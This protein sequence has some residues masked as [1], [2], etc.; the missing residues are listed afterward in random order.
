M[1]LIYRSPSW[2]SSSSSS[3]SSFG[4]V[5]WGLVPFR[6]ETGAFF[7]PPQWRLEE[8]QSHLIVV[9]VCKHQ[10]IKSCDEGRQRPKDVHNVSEL[11]DGVFRRF[12]GNFSR[13]G[14]IVEV[15]FHALAWHFW[16]LCQHLLWCRQFNPPLPLLSHS[17]LRLPCHLLRLALH[18]S[19]SC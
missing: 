7:S 9:H 16:L 15:G 8:I 13:F 12:Y 19:A 6:D 17:L 2:S 4:P 1:F 18:F 5:R 14:C 3:S 10:G 11:R